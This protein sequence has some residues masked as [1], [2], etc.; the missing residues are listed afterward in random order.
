MG[1][2]R[3]AH[4]SLAPV[5]IQ[6][7]HKH[8]TTHIHTERDYSLFSLSFE[9]NPSFFFLSLSYT[10]IFDG[11]IYYTST[12]MPGDTFSISDVQQFLYKSHGSD[13]KQRFTFCSWIWQ[14]AYCPSA[15]ALPLPTGTGELPHASNLHTQGYQ[16]DT[17]THTLTHT[18]QLHI[19]DHCFILI[20][21]CVEF[22]KRNV[23]A[24]RTVPENATSPATEF[25]E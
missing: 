8:M 19:I 4:S 5:D 17:H 14:T 12:Q 16:T 24:N 25:W 10:H 23:S 21:S 9:L 2:L 3:P 22:D 11:E 6:R 7:T 20:D 13:N 1:Y 18:P 15:S